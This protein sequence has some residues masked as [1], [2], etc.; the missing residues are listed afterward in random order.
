M[1]NHLVRPMFGLFLTCVF[2]NTRFDS[3]CHFGECGKSIR[4]FHFFSAL[5]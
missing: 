4:E 3:L 2:F 5:S 1:L